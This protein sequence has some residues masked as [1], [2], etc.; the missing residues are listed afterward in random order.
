M[1]YKEGIL[2]FIGRDYISHLDK[3]N[4]IAD[5][6]L[7]DA[8]TNMDNA[9]SDHVIP[10]D[11]LPRFGDDYSLAMDKGIKR[12][13]TIYKAYQKGKFKDLPYEL[14]KHPTFTVHQSP[15]SWNPESRVLQPKFDLSIT[16]GSIEYQG[17]QSELRKALHKRFAHFGVNFN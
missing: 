9:L 14:T 8:Y 15:D 16:V 1:Y 12:I 3:V 11:R 13:K 6:N 7:L 2:N 5:I 4:I 10:M 17:D